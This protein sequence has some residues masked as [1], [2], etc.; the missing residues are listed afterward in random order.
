[1]GRI[2]PVLVVVE[3]VQ[4][5]FSMPGETSPCA[6]G[7]AWVLNDGNHLRESHVYCWR[8]GCSVMVIICES[9]MCIAGGVGALR[10]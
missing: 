7:A 1:M 3:P 5:N 9:L 4:L 2:P 10:W 6:P 8:R